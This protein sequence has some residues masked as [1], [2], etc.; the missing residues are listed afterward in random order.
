MNAPPSKG[1]A[2]PPAD[3]C[4]C[5]NEECPKRLS[6]LRTCLGN[7]NEATPFA[8]LPSWPACGMYINDGSGIDEEDGE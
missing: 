1:I 8:C 3:L 5:I 7:T 2:F 4:R 6:C